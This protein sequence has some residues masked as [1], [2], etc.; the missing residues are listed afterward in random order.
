MDFANT[1]ELPLFPKRAI[2][3]IMLS[4][5]EVVTRP[6]CLRTFLEANRMS[7]GPQHG[8]YPVLMNAGIDFDSVRIARMDANWRYVGKVHEYM[9]AP[10][11]RWH[12][13]Y[14]ATPEPLRVD[15]RATDH[16]RRFRSQYLIQNTLEKELAIRPN[17]TRS[18]FYLAR[19]YAV[20]SN[21]TFAYS[22][23]EKLAKYSGWDE[24]KYD[25]MLAMGSAAQSLKKPFHF[26]VSTY[27]NV[28]TH[29]RLCVVV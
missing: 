2:F 12:D 21:W 14:R 6:H 27:L 22:T 8:A 4:A 11:E 23:F 17:H 16:D 13:L 1:T 15:F 28:R 9:G 5:D 24:E 7:D 18:L 25:A 19:T 10:D 26:I 20:V 3:G 29:A